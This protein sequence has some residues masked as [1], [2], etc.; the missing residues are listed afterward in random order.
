MPNKYICDAHWHL[1][2]GIFFYC[3]NDLVNKAVIFQS[4]G[5]I[6]ELFPWE[7]MFG[8]WHIVYNMYS[9]QCFFSKRYCLDRILADMDMKVKY[10]IK[11]NSIVKFI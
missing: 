8:T 10:D 7:N 4:D 6:L 9:P 11:T 5:N 1:I 2:K 3:P